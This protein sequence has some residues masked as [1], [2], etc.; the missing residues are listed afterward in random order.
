MK[1]RFHQSELTDYTEPLTAN[2][3]DGPAEALQNKEADA[4][5]ASDA[6]GMTWAAAV[7]HEFPKTDP[8][9][10]RAER[11]LAVLASHA[12]RRRDTIEA[13]LTLT[14]RD[15]AHLLQV[16]ERTMRRYISSGKL[17]AVK[18]GREYRIQLADYDA[19]TEAF[20]VR[21]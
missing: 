3:L 1:R 16:S 17:R 4:E 5:E 6:E 11:A 8:K 14:L 13:R 10:Q 15:A 7:L 18:I 21:R 12:Y 2:Q 19:F 9:R 20:T